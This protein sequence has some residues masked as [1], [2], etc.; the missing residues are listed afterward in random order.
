MNDRNICKAMYDLPDGVI[1]KRRKPLTP[2]TVLVVV[3]FLLILFSDLDHSF[4]PHSMSFAI[5]ALG[6]ILLVAGGVIFAMRAT[7]KYGTPCLRTT[8]RRLLHKEYGFDLKDRAKILEWIKA[9]DIE[10]IVAHKESHVHS[11]IVTLY[12]TADNTFAA[13]QAFEYTDLAFRP[14]TEIRIIRR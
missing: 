8:G 4:V 3:G 2:Y 13:V 12:R 10:R 14:A 11:L 1:I 5:L 7:Q 9:G 6:V